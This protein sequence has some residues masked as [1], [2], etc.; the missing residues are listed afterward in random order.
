MPRNTPWIILLCKF[1]DD[2]DTSK[3]RS[4]ADYAAFFGGDDPDSIPS[5]WRD[6]S[7]GELDLM[8][9]TE[10]SPWL[11][12]EQKR[13]DHTGLSTRGDLVNWAKAAGAKA[14]VDFDRFFG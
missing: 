12:L 4:I 14:G 10:I 5:Y 3:L 1:S 6:I 8:T 2:P 9:G 11:Q 7:S 13:S